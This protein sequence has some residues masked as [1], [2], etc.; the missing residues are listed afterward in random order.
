MKTNGTRTSALRYRSL[1]GSINWLHS[2]NQR[3]SRYQ[4]S[5]CPSA[6]APPTK[7]D[8]KTLNKL[9]RQIVGDPMELSSGQFKVIPDLLLRRMQLSETIV[10]N[11]LRVRW[12]IS[13]LNPEKRQVRTP[14]DPLFSLIPR[15]SRELPSAL[16]LL[17][18]LL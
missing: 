16:L 9:R 13:W 6:A 2:R 12:L 15:R 14:R 10:A 3:Q 17:N 7:G 4:D 11:H 1:L 18:C 8:C 5:R